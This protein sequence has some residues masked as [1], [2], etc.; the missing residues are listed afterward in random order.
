MVTALDWTSDDVSATRSDP[1]DLVVLGGGT[2]GIV[3]A[4][5]AAGLGADVL[6]IERERPG[7]DCLWT[8]CV[9]SKAL[10]SI[11]HDAVA[12]RH[13]RGLTRPG[14]EVE[15]SAVMQTV[16]GVV[17]TI[18]P[19]DSPESLRST[20]VTVIHGEVRFDGPRSVVVDGTSFVFRNAVIA[21]GSS[22]FVPALDGLDT[23]TVLT[24]DSVWDLE[25]L[26]ASLLVLGAGSIGCELGQAL[27][28]LG[29]DVTIVESGNR[30]LPREDEDAAE[31][32]TSALIA[33]GVTLRLGVSV[34]SFRPGAAQLSD[35]S[36]VET[37][38]VLVS[39][40]RR[41]RTAGL[42]L[43][44]AGV[45]LTERGFI[46]VDPRLRTSN[47]RIWAAGDITGH[48]QF[49]HVA[50]S[51]GS[52][53]AT[54]AVLGLRRSVDL[55]TIPRVTYTHPEVAAFGV[56]LQ[57][58]GTDGIHARTV[59]HDE[60]D[61]AIAEGQTDGFSRIVLDRK[62][63]VIGATIVGPRAGES[64]AEV[65]LAARH[66]LRA[67]DIAAAMHAYPTYA[68]GV[69][70]A[71]LAQLQEDLASPWARRAVRVL[72]RLRRWLTRS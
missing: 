64:L 6:L 56:G 47:R 1:W 61:R 16:H 2:A 51:H 63:R 12:G 60:V 39:V 35:G 8:G 41:P 62:Q 31:S 44:E 65:V 34:E 71:A 70:K 55:A 7:G 45:S 69:W 13:G 40:G 23:M 42:G 38:T 10:L 27:A 57:H 18:E 37:D 22:P 21:A 52:M 25:S 28:R 14:G 30:I 11:A 49:T 24:S 67:R 9:P 53:A 66:G 72:L 32:I 43:E 33:D 3:A 58:D 17:A 5:T 68:D 48:P 46:E 36:V 20:G 19:I 50:G 54:N 15:F 29:S 59:G 4:K 26:P